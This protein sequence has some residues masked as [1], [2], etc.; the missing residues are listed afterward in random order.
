[1]N[2]TNIGAPRVE[3]EAISATTSG[4]ASGNYSTIGGDL[5]RPRGAQLAP[6]APATAR[7][8]AGADGI[9]LTVGVVSD[10]APYC[11]RSCLVRAE[12]FDATCEPLYGAL[13]R[14]GTACG[15]CGEKWGGESRLHEGHQPERRKG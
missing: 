14:R 2:M 3:P 15:F 9:P 4:G 6:E 11:S 1:L 8:V 7:G 12:G 13:V 10:K 5:P